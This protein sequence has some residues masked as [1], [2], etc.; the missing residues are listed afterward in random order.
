MY[1]FSSGVGVFQCFTCATVVEPSAYFY[2]LTAEE[3]YSIEFLVKMCTLHLTAD[4][5]A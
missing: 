3:A 2:F 5:V 1:V 4:F